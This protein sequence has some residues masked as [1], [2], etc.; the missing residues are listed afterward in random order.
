LTLSGNTVYGTTYDGGM[1][2]NGTVFRINIDGSGFTNLHSFAAGGYNAIYY[3]NADGANPDA[4]SVL[5]NNILYGT[6]YSGGIGGAGTVFSL[7]TDGSAF[8]SLHIFTAAT[9]ADYTNGDGAYPHASLILSGT[10][11]YGTTLGGGTSA[12]GTIFRV[13]I[14]GGSFTNLHNFTAAPGPAYSNSD[15]G[16]PDAGLFLSGNTLY[17]TASLGGSSGNGTVFSLNTDGS[18]FTELYSFPGGSGGESPGGDLILSGKT[19]FGTTYGGGGAG[20]GAVF[21]LFVAQQLTIVRSGPNVI[22]TWPTNATGLNLQFTTNLLP[23]NWSTN[24]PAPIMA[25]GQNTVT[26]SIS[27]TRMFYRLSP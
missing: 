7:R 8:T 4:G 14:G 15:G 3:T 20:N 17:G 9:N 6:A 5:S 25:N 10:T 12:E 2:G 21:S 22:L 26:N 27:G 11:L 16:E 13:D 18:S 19:L 24:L 23:A 1:A